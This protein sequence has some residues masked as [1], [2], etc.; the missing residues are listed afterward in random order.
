MTPFIVR[1]PGSAM[2]DERKCSRNVCWCVLRTHVCFAIS[3]C[4]LPFNSTLCAL[5]VSDDVKTNFIC[6]QRVRSS[7]TSKNTRATHMSLTYSYVFATFF[8]MNLP[9]TDEPWLQDIVSPL[10]S[11]TNENIWNLLSRC[12]SFGPLWSSHSY[13]IMVSIA[14]TFFSLQKWQRLMCQTRNA[15]IWIYRLGRS[16]PQ[17]L[18]NKW[19]LEREGKCTHL[20]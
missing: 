17:K 14:E 16:H 8:H 3:V 12:P 5:C 9:S 19:I 18:L 2:S 20:A 13:L 1:A 6:H 10:P 15:N 11:S 4:F 7:F